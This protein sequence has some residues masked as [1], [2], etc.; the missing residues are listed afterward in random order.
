MNPLPQFI[1][2]K[3]LLWSLIVS[4]VFSIEPAFAKNEKL[5]DA[6]RK[7]LL[8]ALAGNNANQQATPPTADN[9]HQEVIN[10]NTVYEPQPDAQFSFEPYSSF[11]KEIYPSVIVATAT[12]DKR[13]TPID[14]TDA[15]LYGDWKG[16]VT[17]RLHNVHKDDKYIIEV[18]SDGLI[19]SSKLSFTAKDS[20][21]LVEAAPKLKFDFDVLERNR[22][23][24]PVNITFRVTR[25]G[26]TLNDV[27]QT[28]QLREVNDCPYQVLAKTSK[29]NG[30]IVEKFEDTRFMF[31]AYVNENH[32]WVDQI[33]KE[34]KNTGITSV[35]CG[36]NEGKANLNDVLLQV[37]AIWA[38]LKN[39]K[40]TYS[41]IT[42]TTPSAAGAGVQYV[43]FIDESIRSTQA[44]CVDGSVLMAS[45]LK[46]IGIK[47]LLVLVP[48]HCYLAFWTNDQ[49][50]GGQLCGLET[51]MLGTSSFEDAI[52]FANRNSDTSLAHILPKCAVENSGYLLVDIENA[53]QLGIMPLPY[54]R[55]ARREK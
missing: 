46:K 15:T 47:P 45:I 17:L 18:E 38:A 4:L 39:R 1:Q 33:L 21:V 49:N 22:Q 31:A 20:E 6:L 42:D 37:K 11:G 27:D 16:A 26:E 41:S 7:A 28:W 34:A 5:K 51:T 35:F 43:R 53:R 8:E 9:A 48:G 12:I 25:N 24:R 13:L 19:E 55:S 10:P 54:I 14:P 2:K 40:M 36:Y 3:L 30:N 29:R 50:R 44:N 32:P 23:T 52:N